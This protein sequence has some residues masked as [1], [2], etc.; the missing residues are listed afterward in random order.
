[1]PSMRNFTIGNIHTVWDHFRWLDV[2]T[3]QL[4]LAMS[5]LLQLSGGN[6]HIIAGDFNSRPEMPPYLFMEHGA[7]TP[8]VEKQLAQLAAD[9]ADGQ[10]L[11][12]LLS[13]YY[14]H[15]SPSLASSYKAGHD[16]YQV[17]GLLVSNSMQSLLVTCIND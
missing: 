2:S 16:K 8:A 3:L 13:S 7:L 15:S 1:M 11:S 12:Q 6:G 17:F 5:Q 4:S 14:S 9:R 10:P